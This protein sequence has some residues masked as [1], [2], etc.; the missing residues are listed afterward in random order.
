MSSPRPWWSGAPVS[1][2]HTFIS[3]L[4]KLRS[5]LTYHCFSCFHLFSFFIIS[6]LYN[7]ISQNVFP[8]N[9]LKR[10]TAFAISVM[11][12][13]YS[14]PVLL[15]TIRRGN[16]RISLTSW[17]FIL[18]STW[19]WGSWTIIAKSRN[20]RNGNKSLLDLSTKYKR[21]SS[22]DDKEGEKEGG[23]GAMGHQKGFYLQNIFNNINAYV[24]VN[25]YCWG[26]LS[27]VEGR[28]SKWF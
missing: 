3:R 21:N 1:E 18:P 23:D 10:G 22:G 8:R 9:K 11:L 20:I 17:A 13:R 5:I 27:M 6:C 19:A 7:L 14:L 28:F 2:D 15:S 12:E 26:K 24:R 4:V 25:C 16:L